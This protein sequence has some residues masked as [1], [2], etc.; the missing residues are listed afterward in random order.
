VV[1]VSIVMPC[2]NEAETLAAC[3]RK[4]LAAIRATGLEE[5]VLVA[6]NGSTD[7][8]QAIAIREGARVIDVP[9]R[10]YG[11]ALMAG[12]GCAAGQYILM[13][14]ADDSY[15]FSHLSRFVKA[16]DGGADLVM[17]NRFKGG[18]PGRCDAFSAP[19]CWKSR[20]EFSRPRILSRPRLLFP[21]WNEGLYEIS[22]T[23]IEPED[24]RH[25]VCQ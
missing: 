23:E 14:D 17:G 10:G 5:E 16:L 11:A 24:H 1:S 6:D 3:I 25:G 8:S 19:V 21:L 22:Y 13:A 18:N 15:D 2:L 4:G 9:V 12:I 7:G 20:V